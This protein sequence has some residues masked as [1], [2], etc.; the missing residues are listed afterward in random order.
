M[1]PTE[2]AAGALRR[3]I[4]DDASDIRQDTLQALRKALAA[5]EAEAGQ[6]P[7]TSKTILDGIAEALETRGYAH[8]TNGRDIGRLLD[9]KETL[10]A[11]LRLP[12]TQEREELAKRLENVRFHCETRTED[13]TGAL[14]ISACLEA[15]AIVRLPADDEERLPTLLW[16]RDK[17]I[18]SKDLW[19][20][21][22]DQLPRELL[23]DVR[24]SAA[25]DARDWQ[26]APSAELQAEIGRLQS[27]LHFKVLGDPR[28]GVG[29]V[30]DDAPNPLADQSPHGP[31]DD[32]DDNTFG[33][34]LPAAADVEAMATLPRHV[35]IKYLRDC[36][37][38]N[39]PPHPDDIADAANLLE[40]DGR[41]IAEFERRL[42]T[43]GGLRGPTDC[44][45][46]QGYW[47]STWR[48]IEPCPR[49]GYGPCVNQGE[50]SASTYQEEISAPT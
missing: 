18:V 9:E 27:I 37:D 15:A 43:G 34:S 16:E 17:F 40:E 49:C 19:Q 32:G 6:P 23:F 2:Q 38:A 31:H 3:A 20:E 47:P 28:V 35:L 33:P 41:R 26:R 13:C 25:A 8:M 11:A 50:I 48:A 29:A 30:A 22:V 21:F 5:L 14:D 7:D 44:A 39:G 46:D 42:A 36:L 12:T 10:E 4:H 45:V 24:L 1:T